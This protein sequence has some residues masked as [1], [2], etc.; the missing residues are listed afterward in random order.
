ME[1][2]HPYSACIDC[3]SGLKTLKCHLELT[4][5][6]GRKHCWWARGGPQLPARLSTPQELSE[7][8]HFKSFA[9]SRTKSYSWRLAPS[10]G[11]VHPSPGDRG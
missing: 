2:P 3:A 1:L 9:D 8:C 11:M 4:P 7:A 10:F 5:R 6:A